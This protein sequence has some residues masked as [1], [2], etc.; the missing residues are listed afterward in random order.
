LASDRQAQQFNFT[1]SVP[2]NNRETLLGQKN[3]EKS[4][5]KFPDFLKG[6]IFSTLQNIKVQFFAQFCR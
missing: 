6:G 2:E 3:F 5:E 4:V 1:H